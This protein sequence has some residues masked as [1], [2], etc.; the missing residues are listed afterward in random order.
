VKL[1]FDAN[2]SPALV[3]RL[4]GAFPESTHIRDI[5]LR[6]APDE[7]IWDYAKLNG[8][9]IVSKDSDF[10]ERSFVEGFP[11]KVI[12]LD[13]GNAGTTK[14]ASLLQRERGRIEEF[15]ASADSSLL[16]LS[17]DSAAI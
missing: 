8:M 14:V 12:W 13:V 15:N 9:A 6:E 16:V 3:G 11:P 7:A 10:R 4:A 17:L 5:G 1:L 2:L